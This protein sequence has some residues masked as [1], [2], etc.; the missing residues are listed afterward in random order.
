MKVDSMPFEFRELQI[1][2][3]LVMSKFNVVV[4]DTYPKS[5]VNAPILM[6]DVKDFK[7]PI[8]VMPKP[9]VEETTINN[10]KNQN[11]ID[12]SFKTLN[13]PVKSDFIGFNEK[14]VEK[15]KNHYET[16]DLNEIVRL[17]KIKNEL[18]KELQYYDWDFVKNQLNNEK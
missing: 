10:D 13:N 7:N 12:N 5:V 4:D 18:F 3:T 1:G 9:K 8:K 16:D 6:K 14:N 2:E 15:P 17:N 11:N